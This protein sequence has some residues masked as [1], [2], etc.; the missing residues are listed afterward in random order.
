[1]KASTD[2]TA[3]IV[4]LRRV[5]QI[6][7]TA[8]HMLVELVCNLA[9]HG[10]HLDFTH[11]QSHSRFRRFLEEVM[12]RE[13]GTRVTTFLDLDLALEWCET[14]LI[15]EYAPA[16]KSLGVLRLADHHLSQGL[17]EADVAYLE[18][19]V[20]RERFNPGDLIIQQGEGADK[21]YFL[22]SGEVS[23]IVE[24]PS[25]RLKRL[26]TVS[27]GM[28]FG[29]FAFVDGGARSADVR[30]DTPVECYTLTKNDFEHLAKTHAELK[31]GLLYNLLRT[32][33]RIANRMTEEVMALEG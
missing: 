12:S 13:D 21:L 3:A 7:S 2:L 24:L 20:T 9:A 17:Q 22:M 5:T 33:T 26:A 28:G 29:E 16:H 30:A 15:A 1:V 18:T 4:D 19:V 25:G 11:V 27:A 14:R 23:V 32:V 10:K 6:D 31:S 8:G